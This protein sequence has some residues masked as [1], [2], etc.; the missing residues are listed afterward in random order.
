[1]NPPL[2][3]E[4][5]PPARSSRGC[6]SGTVE[7]IATDHAPHASPREGGALRGGADG[8][9]RPGDGVRRRSTPNSS[10]PGSSAL[11]LVVERLTAGVALYG[12]LD[13]RRIA[14]GEA[15][16][17]HPGRP[18]RRPGWP[19]R[20]GTRAGRTNSCLPWPAPAWPGAAHGRGGRGR[21]SADRCSSPAA[22]PHR[23][24]DDVSAE[25]YVLLEDGA[26]VRRSV[27]SEPTTPAVGEVVFTTSMAGYQEAMTDPSYA[28]QLIAF[29]FPAGRQLRGVRAAAMESDR[30]RTRARRSCAR[31]ST[32]PTPRRPRQ[33]WCGWLDGTG[34][35]RPSPAVDT[36]AL[37]RHI[38]DAGSMRGGVFPATDRPG[39]GAAR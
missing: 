29:T 36:R 17:P 39:R 14:V 38:R 15:G 20:T 1:M 10:C 25:A 26:R 9:H 24:D 22:S 7:C 32:A 19:A 21:P 34:G 5:R 37:V 2:R 8:H 11:G 13:A 35:R 12:L 31:R 30:V 4:S 28:G 23:A 6:A 18:R 3:A 27:P 16:E 33:G